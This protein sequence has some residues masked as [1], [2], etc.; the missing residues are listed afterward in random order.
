MGLLNDGALIDAAANHADRA[1]VGFA[2]PFP[3]FSLNPDTP[4]P[5]PFHATNAAL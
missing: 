4:N 5:E 1:R 2:P 3:S